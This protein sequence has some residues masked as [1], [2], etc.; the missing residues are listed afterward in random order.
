MYMYRCS[1]YIQSQSEFFSIPNTA[2]VVSAPTRLCLVDFFL[3]L[4]VELDSMCVSPHLI[5]ELMMKSLLYTC[6][7]HGYICISWMCMYCK[8][9]F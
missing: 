5:L 7:G 1:I 3:K 8:Y 9:V 2:K 6:N 4:H